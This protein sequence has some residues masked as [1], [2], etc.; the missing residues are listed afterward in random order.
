MAV[1]LSSADYA[2]LQNAIQ[3]MTA[4]PAP[5]IPFDDEV[6]FRSG[7]AAVNSGFV[8]TDGQWKQ[9]CQ[10]WPISTLLSFAAF[11]GHP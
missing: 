4:D 9:K 8:K 3:L 6:I 10:D 11:L 2:S 5:E 1:K 7:P